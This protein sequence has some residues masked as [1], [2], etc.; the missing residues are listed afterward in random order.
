MLKVW[1]HTSPVLVRVC[2]LFCFVFVICWS[3]LGIRWLR[4]TPAS[5]PLGPTTDYIK[6]STVTHDEYREWATRVWSVKTSSLLLCL[7][8]LLFCFP[9]Y[10]YARALPFREQEFDN[11]QKQLKG[12]TCS[13]GGS[14]QSAKVML[15]SCIGEDY[16][17]P[18]HDDRW[19]VDGAILAYFGPPG[20]TQRFCFPSYKVSVV[21]QPGDVLLFDSHLIHC[22]EAMGD[23]YCGRMLISSYINKYTLAHLDQYKPRF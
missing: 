15:S 4:S 9:R 6:K 20:S 22:A 12:R 3:Y 17:A 16:S 23:A 14:A 10:M 11:M 18:T 1:G 8:S 19:D 5:H 21:L 13:H 7:Q 2:I